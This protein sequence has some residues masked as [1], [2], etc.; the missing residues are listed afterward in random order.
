MKVTVFGAYGHTGRFIV[1]ELRRRGWTAVLSGRDREKLDA[2]RE[3][4]PGSACRVASVDDPDSLDRALAGSAAVING[5][6][7]FL[8]T[9]GT[10]IEAA[11]R[12]RI[13]YLDIAAEQPAVLSAFERFAD[14]ARRRGV[15]V[16]PAMAFYGGLGDL[17]ASAA[18]VGWDSA[19][20]ISIAVA[21]DSWK[22]T[23]GTRL[24]GERNPGPRFVFSNGSLTRG[25]L[26]PARTWD[27]P[28]PFG[29]QDVVPLPLAETIVI[30]RHL[31]IRDLRMFLSSAPIAELRNPDTPPPSPSDGTGRSAQIFA[32]DLVVRRGAEERRLA[33]RGRDIYA[34][35]APLVVEAMERIVEGRVSATGVVAPGE[36]FDALDFLRALGADGA[37][38]I[39]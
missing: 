25:E 6:G 28:S 17:M 1:A 26:P 12:A 32:M 2:L 7:P 3:T 21:L 8:D 4:F 15:V 22:P 29:R 11:I 9:A 23:R 34:V 31:R 39:A 5:A 33:A 24:T 18:M 30:P 35:T 14:E 20:E 37:I 13:P 36:A 16:I 38:E 27:F 10:L 19:D